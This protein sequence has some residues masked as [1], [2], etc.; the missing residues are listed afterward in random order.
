MKYIKKFIGV[1]FEKTNDYS[2]VP[3][4]WVFEQDDATYF[5]KWPTKG[6]VEQMSKEEYLPTNKWKPFKCDILLESSK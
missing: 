5:C 2:V 3:L 4:S 1:Y 6:D